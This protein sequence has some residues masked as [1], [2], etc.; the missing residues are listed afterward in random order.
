MIVRRNV[1]FITTPQIDPWSG[2]E[3][4][5]SR[6]AIELVSQGFLVSASV[7]EGSLQHPRMQELQAR[8]VD[9]W[10]WPRWSSLRDV[11]TDR[12]VWGKSPWRRLKL[13][14][15]GS[16]VF[17][18]ERLLKAMTP[19]IA[20]L[21]DGT[22]LPPIQLLELCVAKRMPFVTV[23]QA[24]SEAFCYDDDLAKRYRAALAAALR[25]FFVAQANR[26]LVE[27]QIGGELANAEIVRNPFNVSYNGS[28]PW[29]TSSTDAAVRFACVGR[30]YPPAKG[31]DILFE[32]L[33]QSEWKYRNWRLSI[34]G[35][36]PARSSLEWLARRLGLSKRVRF[37][38]FAKPEEIW[39]ENHVL[40][41]P[42]RYEGLPLVMVEA[43][44]CSRPIV[45]TNIAG[46]AEIV[47][48]GVTGFLA[49]APTPPAM[50]AALEKF[51]ARRTEAE[52][53][54]KAG[55]DRIR[56]LVPPDPVRVLVEKLVALGGL[57]AAH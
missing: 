53:M 19:A 9:F 29:P 2:A 1:V 30:L 51:W 48:E 31:Q 11:I 50:A 25:C 42:S 49:D 26:W 27:K 32:A 17:A 46:H 21:S 56:E 15:N 35:E 4:L 54:G 40:L 6:T 18:V 16:V 24:G 23:S 33:A 41:M 22:T 12:T 8:G 45:A 43:M 36:G 47:E 20:V 28:F 55:H 52:E 34:Y 10:P 39:A 57:V 13:G 38:G 44:L 5:W 14:R 3:E 37:A 7:W